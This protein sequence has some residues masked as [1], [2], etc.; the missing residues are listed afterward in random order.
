MTKRTKIEITIA[1]LLISI[2]FIYS[3]IQVDIREIEL[4]MMA[5]IILTCLIMAPCAYLVAGETWKWRAG[6]WP[7]GEPRL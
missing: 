3:I 4:S 7:Y 5:S 1:I 2:P 6:K